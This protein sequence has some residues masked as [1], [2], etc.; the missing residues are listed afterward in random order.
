ML[1]ATLTFFCAAAAV[2]K[3]FW[4]VVFVCAGSVMLA[5]G[6]FSGWIAHRYLPEQK[7]IAE[8]KHWSSPHPI[9]GNQPVPNQRTRWR[10]FIRG[11]QVFDIQMTMN[12]DG[13]R[14]TPQA[15]H[16]ERSILFFGC[17]LVTPNWLSAAS[18][19]L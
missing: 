11:K 7:F 3:N 15:P 6:V 5:V 2:K 1:A 14:I 9:L 10:E 19:E 4:S 16:A 13:L 17:S 18:G 12:G 8:P